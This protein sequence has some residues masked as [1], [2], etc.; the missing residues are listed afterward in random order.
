MTEKKKRFLSLSV[1]P[2]FVLLLGLVL[3]VCMALLAESVGEA[4]IGRCYL[5]EAAVLKRTNRAAQELQGYVRQNALTTRNTNA[6]AQW[7]ESRKD[8]YI[9]LYRDQRQ[10]LEIGWWGADIA[11]V[12]AYSLKEQGGEVVYPIAFRDGTVYAV[13]Y[14][15][16][17]S[18]LYDLT[19]IVSLLL[20]CAV[21]ALTLLAYNR[22]VARKVVAI[23]HEVQS[24]GEGNLYL[25]LEPKG[26]DE[27]AQLTA[28]VEQMR[29]SLLRKTSE[30]QRALQQNSDLITAMSHDIRNPLT[31]LLGY[32]DLAK[33]GQYRTQEELQ[34]YLD[35][36]YGKTEQL[37][38]LT[39]ELFRYSLLFGC[40]ELPLQ[41]ERYDAS[42]LL[43]QLLGESRA[44]LQ[45]QGFTVQLLLPQQDVQIEA[46][47]TY[48]KRVFDNL[49][50]NI[51]KYADPARGHR[52]AAG[53]WGAARLPVQQREPRRGA[54]R[55]QQD[56]AA[57]L[58]EDHG[59]DVGQLQA[60]Y[61][62][63]EV[64]RRGHPSHPARRGPGRQFLKI[65]EFC[66]AGLFFASLFWYDTGNKMGGLPHTAD[67]RC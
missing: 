11:A 33:T 3:G 51:R 57:H 35:A 60:L 2:L 16:S 23:S 49:F 26:S 30:E 56:R 8:Y 25:Q 67:A 42:I 45:Q 27:L 18:R 55:I 5:N 29:L 63:R 54:H 58:R 22:R 34:S 62:E 19:W 47:V 36:A 50:D 65:S 39:D 41:L 9:L 14:D 28:S 44:Q 52:S 31:A 6:L 1:K 24:I 15:N 21:L 40:K 53:G 64:H 37:K 7:G 20:G 12:D 32:L 17:D 59:A 38:R 48:L 43:G 66:N 10:I 61:R 13:I 4:I 46:D